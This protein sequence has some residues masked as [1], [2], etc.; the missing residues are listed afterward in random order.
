M[1]PKIS[2]WPNINIWPKI[3][4]N[5]NMRPNTPN[6]PVWH[7]DGYV[8]PGS[9]FGICETLMMQNNQKPPE[10]FLLFH[11]TK[12]EM[13][14]MTRIG[15]TCCKWRWRWGWGWWWGEITLGFV[16]KPQNCLLCH[17]VLRKGSTE[18]ESNWTMYLFHPVSLLICQLRSCEILWDIVSIYKNNV[19]IPKNL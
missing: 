19:W 5:I 10:N 4:Q 17:Q 14:I 12:T 8:F 13:K 18:S 2:I 3:W 11:M 1:Q 15:E 6:F 16:A 7:R 9:F